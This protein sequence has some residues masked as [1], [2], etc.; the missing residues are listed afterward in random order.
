VSGGM[1]LSGRR[2]YAIFLPLRL[3]QERNSENF[4]I[5]SLFTKKTNTLKETNHETWCHIMNCTVYVD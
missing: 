1:A 3:Q 4:Q 5:F 2:T